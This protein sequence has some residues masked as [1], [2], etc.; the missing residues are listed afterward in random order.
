MATL[1]AFWAKA[2][3]FRTFLFAFAV[4]LEALLEPLVFGGDI[5]MKQ[6]LLATGIA[7]LRAVTR[8]PPGK[9]E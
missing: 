6:M 2:R 4:A 9:G 3:G 5:S 8:T 1:R 7:A